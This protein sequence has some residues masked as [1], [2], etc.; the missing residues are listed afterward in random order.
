MSGL[1]VVVV[2][3]VTGVTTFGGTTVVAVVT[4]AGLEV[5]GATVDACVERRCPP[6]LHPA[7]S[8]VVIARTAKDRFEGF[9][10]SV[11]LLRTRVSARATHREHRVRGLANP[12]NGH[13]C[14]L[15]VRRCPSLL[16]KI[17]L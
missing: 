9:C 13:D 10:I 16:H 1:P 15:D 11:P 8:A 5:T 2:A 17:R 3:V 7:T 12:K 6:L 14:I 4:G